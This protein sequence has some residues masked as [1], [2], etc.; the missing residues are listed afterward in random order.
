M[1]TPSYS[2]GSG[3]LRCLRSQN[4]RFA[5]LQQGRDFFPMSRQDL[6]RLGEHRGFFVR[7]MLLDLRSQRLESGLKRRIVVRLLQGLNE[8]LDL[9][10][11]L[12]RITDQ[13]LALLVG[14]LGNGRVE[15]RFF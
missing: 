13:P 15:Y 8:F 3:H 1:C 4:L 6:H 11:V 2:S 12:Q 5:L 10:M 7:D 14:L 9:L